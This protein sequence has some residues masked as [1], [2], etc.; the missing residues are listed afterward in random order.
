MWQLTALEPP[1]STYILKYLLIK[2]HFVLFSNDL[3]RFYLLKCC[4]IVA[5][6]LSRKLLHK[7]KRIPICTFFKVKLN[8]IFLFTW[9]ELHFTVA[10]YKD[11]HNKTNHQS[12]T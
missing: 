6:M 3:T 1:L 2:N 12:N 4:D 5:S 9:H 7:E 10:I 11:R 8:V